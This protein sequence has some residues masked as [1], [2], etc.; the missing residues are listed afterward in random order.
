MCENRYFY[1]G[2]QTELRLDLQ[3]LIHHNNNST[4][5]RWAMADLV[6]FDCNCRLGPDQ[7]A[8]E[9]V[10]LDAESLLRMMDR[11][12]INEALVYSSLSVLYAPSVGN[13]RILENTSEHGRLHPC[14][15]LL[16]DNTGELP[17]QALSL[18]LKSGANAARLMPSHHRFSLSEWCCG[19]MLGELAGAGVPVFLDYGI[20]HWSGNNVDWEA[21]ECLCWTHPLLPVVLCGL[22][23]ADNRFLYPLLDR[24]PNLRIDLSYYQVEG[25]VEEI[26]SRFGAKRMLFGTAA[27]KSDPGCAISYIS[28]A[29]IPEPDKA[30]IAGGNLKKLLQ[31]VKA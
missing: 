9:G 6:F 26:H 22:G 13:R 4:T 23:M 20:E 27:P 8:A 5:V 28:Y 25:G 29:R 21:V 16:P 1:G 19:P 30:A 2:Q 10:P 18:M 17:D 24:H 14:W 12:G 31:G 11:V 15:V 3:A 7:F